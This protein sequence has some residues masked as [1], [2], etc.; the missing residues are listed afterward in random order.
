MILSTKWSTI[1]RILHLSTPQVSER[2][3]LQ[4]AP[5]FFLWRLT[6][7]RIIVFVPIQLTKKL[8]STLE[9]PT[10]PFRTIDQAGMDSPTT[11]LTLLE[12]TQQLMSMLLDFGSQSSHPSHHSLHIL[13]FP[14]DRSRI[15][16]FLLDQCH[17]ER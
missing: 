2:L 7:V 14:S 11:M 4:L 13:R 17:T 15:G 12:D 8:L 1:A 9:L 6:E 16:L 10:I 3:S 5:A